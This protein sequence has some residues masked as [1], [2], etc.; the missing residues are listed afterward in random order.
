MLL[1]YTTDL[2]VMLTRKQ[3]TSKSVK[4]KNCNSYKIDVYK[5]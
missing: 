2:A 1:P 4:E 5:E 3:Y